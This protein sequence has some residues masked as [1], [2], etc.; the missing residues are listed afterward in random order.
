MEAVE[1]T[2]VEISY[3]EK[4]IAKSQQDTERLNDKEKVCVIYLPIC[5]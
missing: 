4:A 1:N 2:T 3:L 5:V